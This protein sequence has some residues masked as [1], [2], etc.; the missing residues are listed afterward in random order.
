MRS[1][2]RRARGRVNF[3]SRS[4]KSSHWADSVG[5][6]ESVF[7]L[8]GTWLESARSSQ[9]GPTRAT[10]RSPREPRVDSSG[11]W[12]WLSPRPPRVRSLARHYR[13]A[14]SRRRC[15]ELRARRDR[16]WVRAPRRAPPLP[17][18]GPHSA[19][20]KP[21]GTPDPTGRVRPLTY[22]RL[23]PWRWTGDNPRRFGCVLETLTHLACGIITQVT[24]SVLG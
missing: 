10:R 24:C 4:G 11:R 22:R 6:S 2:G 12:P 13:R 7:I 20:A 14:V 21:F 18:V 16:R 3:A 17:G 15:Y 8:S 1:R 9:L 19:K 5:K 23:A